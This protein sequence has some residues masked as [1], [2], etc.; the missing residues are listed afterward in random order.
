MKLSQSNRFL[1]DKTLAMAGLIA[2]ARTSSGIEGIRQPFE[3]A[4]KATGITDVRSFTDY[5]KQRAASKFV[6]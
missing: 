3:R 1:Q 4:L 6:K 5:W 2:S